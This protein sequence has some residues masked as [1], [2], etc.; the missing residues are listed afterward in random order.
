MLEYKGVEGL[1]EIPMYGMDFKLKSELADLNYY[2]YGPEENY[3]DRNEG[4]RLG[5][6]KSTAK[7]NISKYLIPQ[8]CGNRT[9]TRWVEGN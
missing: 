3:I 2:G 5:V 7:E 9:G 6:Y 4:A 1:S 8:E